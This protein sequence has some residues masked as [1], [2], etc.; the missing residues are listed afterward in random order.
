MFTTGLI[1]TLFLTANAVTL[2]MLFEELGLKSVDI[3]V[4]DVEGN[5]LEILSHYDLVYQAS[6]FGY[7]N[8]P[9]STS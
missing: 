1:G 9:L 5:E 8:S 6:I 4:M 2:K 3:L 7:R